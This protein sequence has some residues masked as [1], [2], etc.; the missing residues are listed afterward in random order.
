[1]EELR[2][3]R[4]LCRRRDR[5]VLAAARGGKSP[6]QISV[7]MGKSVSLVKKILVR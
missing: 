4:E 5:L 3:Y 6:P 1:M 2:E 7:A